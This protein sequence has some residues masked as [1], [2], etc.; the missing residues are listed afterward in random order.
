MNDVLHTK[1]KQ[2]FRRRKGYYMAAKREDNR[3]GS[4]RPSVCLHV[5]PCSLGWT[6]WP[7]TLSF[8]HGVDLDL[9]QGGIVVQGR[10]SMVKVKCHISCFTSMLP[11]FKVKVRVKVKGQGK[12]SGVQQAICDIRGSALPSAAKSNRSCYQSKVFVCVSVISGCII[13]RV[14]G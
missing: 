3:F 9:G 14:F 13:H 12:L 7:L 11:C 8:W 10:K 5:C 6:V 4:V 2:L 1:R